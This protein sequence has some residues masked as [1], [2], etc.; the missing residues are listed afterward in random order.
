MREPEDYR[1]FH[2]EI[3]RGQDLPLVIDALRRLALSGGLNSKIHLVNDVVMMAVAS[4]YPFERLHN[5]ARCLSDDAPRTQRESLGIGP[6]GFLGSAYGARDHVRA[7]R[8]AIRAGL[9]P[10]ATLRFFG[11][12]SMRALERLL[13]VWSR[14]R[15]TPT[16]KSV[17][18]ALFARLLGKS[19]EVMEAAPHAHG[20]GKGIPT[21]YFLR[22]AY[23]RCRARKPDH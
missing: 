2:F 23:F 22:H 15:R 10:L 17:S 8:R 21:E 6:W 19:Y 18:D 5:G 20:I 9:Q 14:A 1:S 4:R 16:G 12:P 7:S 11:D 13:S 3:R